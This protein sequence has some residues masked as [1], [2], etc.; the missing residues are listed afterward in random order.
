[1]NDCQKIFDSVAA[2]AGFICVFA[3]LILR[4]LIGLLGTLM[5]YR[6]QVASVYLLGFFLDLVNMF[7][8]NVAYPDI[9]RHFNAPLSQLAWVSNAYMLGLTLVIPISGWLASRVGGKRVLMASLAL[10]M[11]ATCGVGASASLTQLIVWRGL[12]GMGGGLLIPLGQT[13]TY[14]LF[15]PHERAKLSSAVMLVALLAPALSPALGGVL[16]EHL[17]WR[18][19]FLISLPLALLTFTLAGCGLKQEPP[20]PNTEPL[21][22]VGLVSGCA[23]LTLLLL[24]LTWLGE[25]HAAARGAATL[26][27]GALCLTGFIR[28]SLRTRAPLLNLRLLNA[29]RLRTAMLLYHGVPGVFT[30]VNLLA[31]LYLQG[32][33]GMRATWVGAM[34]L[35]WAAAAFVAISLTGK[36]FNRGGPRPLFLAGCVTQALGMGL[37]ATLAHDGMAIRC[38]A[39]FALMGFGGS[40]VSSAAQSAA[41]VD[42]ADADL[43]DAS[44]LWNIN[45]QLS[46]CG[47]VTLMSLLF[48]LLL[49]T[50]QPQA[51]AYRLCFIFA[52]CS[53]AIPL[54]CCMRLAN[55]PGISPLTQEKK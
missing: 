13:L 17:G 27:A 19:V 23:A 42:L 11:L 47:G 6:V 28:H 8:A 21:D 20:T 14:A 7:I 5:R 15:R 18:G 43:A 38:A 22:S 4:R 55:T 1:M 29:P 44:A 32:P 50:G 53:A 41:F 49:L 2:A 24:G 3:R 40:L 9:G 48:A 52:A 26:L 45:R 12:Q 33:L 31:M 36:T 25:A 16:V 30:G 10:F 35:P 46:F 54:L 37:L 34:M 39:A 51:H